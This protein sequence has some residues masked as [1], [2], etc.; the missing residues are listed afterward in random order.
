[1]AIGHSP[2]VRRPQASPECR[3]QGTQGVAESEQGLASGLVNTSLQIGGALS[4][5]IAAALLG[6]IDFAEGTEMGSAG[7]R[8]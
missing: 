2:R 6:N 5:A 8:I 4:L 3:R 7:S 1:M